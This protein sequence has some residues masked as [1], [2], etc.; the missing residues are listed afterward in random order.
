VCRKDY[1]TWKGGTLV[2]MDAF[3]GLGHDGRRCRIIRMGGQAK[4]YGWKSFCVAGNSKHGPLGK[5]SRSH[6]MQ[7]VACKS[8]FL[9]GKVDGK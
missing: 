1:R 4:Q 9:L 3:S 8:S 2:D 5:A 6:V 7:I